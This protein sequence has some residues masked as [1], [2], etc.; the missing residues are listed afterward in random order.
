MRV[1][2]ILFPLTLKISNFKYYASFHFRDMKTSQREVKQLAQDNRIGKAK[3][4]TQIQ[5]CQ[6]S[7]HTVLQDP[8]LFLW[9]YVPVLGL[10][11]SNC[12]LS[13]A[14]IPSALHFLP[15]NF[16]SSFLC[17]YITTP[18]YKHLGFASK[19]DQRQPPMPINLAKKCLIA[20][21]PG[22]T[23]NLRC[24]LHW[25]V[26]CPEY[27][28]NIISECVGEDVSG[29]GALYSADGVQ[30]P[31]SPIVGGPHPICWGLEEN[32]KENR[33]ISFSLLELGHWSALR[34]PGC[35]A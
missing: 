8:M 25:V 2:S 20:S 15:P 34:P 13:P 10:K 16:S 17:Y 22:L 1:F 31:A 27:W 18:V 33:E 11:I 5:S 21:T 14:H 3:D 6:A 32:K 19:V 7:N 23:A 12:R 29:R 4:K 30:Q 26:G 24:W 35:Q 28:W 9:E